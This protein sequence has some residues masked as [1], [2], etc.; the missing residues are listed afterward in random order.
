M[1]KAKDLRKLIRAMTRRG[2][3]VEHGG[4][5]PKLVSPFGSIVTFSL[6]PHGGHEVR[7][8]LRAINHIQRANGLPDLRAD[9]EIK[10]GPAAASPETSEVSLTG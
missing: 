10:K 6:S 2:W 5:H 4:K 9:G 7:N 1:S 3:R 8:V